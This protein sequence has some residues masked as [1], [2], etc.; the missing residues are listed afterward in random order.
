MLQS[1]NFHIHVH[2]TLYMY[3]SKH[4]PLDFTQ[5]DECTCTE[6]YTAKTCMKKFAASLSYTS[7]IS[8]KWCLCLDSIFERYSPVCLFVG[9]KFLMSDFLHVSKTAFRQDML[10]EHSDQYNQTGYL[11]KCV[12]RGFQ[13]YSPRAGGDTLDNK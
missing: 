1:H 3:L 8:L 5:I 4:F 7:Q 2:C 10:K 12:R 6:T 9:V 13:L 11:V